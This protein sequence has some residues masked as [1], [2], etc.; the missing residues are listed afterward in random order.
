MKRFLPF[1]AIALAACLITQAPASDA[2]ISHADSFSKEGL[3]KADVSKLPDTEF[4]A[5]PDLPL[6]ATKNIL[7][8]GTLQLAWNEAINLVGEKLQFITQPP[9]VDLLNQ[10]DF[11]RADL[12]SASY[13]AL[14]DFEHN[15]VETEIRAAL[16]KTFGGAASPELIPPTPTNPGPYDFVAYAYLYKNLAFAHPFAKNEPLDFSG[17]KVKNFGFLTDKERLDPAV[18]DQVEID[19]YASSDDFIITLQTKA[20]DDQLILAKIAPGATM[21][22][23]I[24]G[25][26]QRIA[27]RNGHY[28]TATKR[29]FM[30]VPDLNFDLG[31]SFD[32][33]IGL[34]LKP[35]PNI[36]V[37][38][39]V[40]SEVKQLIR[41]QL[42]EKGAVLKSEAAMTM[43]GSAVQ[44]IPPPP[45]YQLIFDKPFLIL[46]KQAK[47]DQPYF[48]MWIGN[49]S[50]L[51]PAK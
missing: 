40:T 21:R 42:N 23:T 51:I 3:I 6:D 10:E 46:M 7:W 16:E 47:S 20:S 48:T 26:L 39:L 13:V 36:K 37:K 1:L 38:N 19:D 34:T 44:M 24:A 33:L 17:H 43:V 29:D 14:A 32:E 9:E 11:T 18:F 4:L 5:H 27:S 41:F 22:A 35:G 31:K 12:D 45:P 15:H 2:P 50:L 25:V 28:D 49:A 8:C 30:A